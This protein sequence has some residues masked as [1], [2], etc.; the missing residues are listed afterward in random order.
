MDLFIPPTFAWLPPVVARSAI[1]MPMIMMRLTT[2]KTLK[3]RPQQVWTR[4]F[5]TNEEENADEVDGG[6][7]G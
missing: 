6:G 7:G 2:T 3:Q 1:S 4:S 5:V